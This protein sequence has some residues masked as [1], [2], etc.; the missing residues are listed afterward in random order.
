MLNELTTS[1][2]EELADAASGVPLTLDSFERLLPAF[3]RILTRR[4]ESLAGTV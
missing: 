2:I 4:A 3:D 1:E